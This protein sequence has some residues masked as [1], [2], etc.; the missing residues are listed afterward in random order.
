MKAVIIGLFLL[1]APASARME[2]RTKELYDAAYAD[3]LAAVKLI[4]EESDQ[5]V[6]VPYG[7]GEFSP[8]MPACRNGNLEMAELLV[9]KGADVSAADRYGAPVLEYVKMSSPGTYKRLRELIIKTAAGK[10]IELP[11]SWQFITL[12]DDM[13][14]T[15]AAT[16]DSILPPANMTDGEPKTAWAGKTGDELWVFV[17]YGTSS[18]TVT[19]GYNKTP[20]LFKAN[21]RVKRMAVSIWAAA[22][23]GGDVTEI[24]KGF[25]VTRLTPDHVITLKDSGAGQSFALPFDW[26]EID[27]SYVKAPAALFKR[28]NFGDNELYD[29]YFT[30]RAEPLEAYPGSKYDDT[31]I[32]ELRAGGP[33]REEPHLRG[34]WVSAE[35]TD[36]K[37][38]VFSTRENDRAF[39]AYR[40]GKPFLNGSWRMENGELLVETEGETSRYKPVVERIKY[41]F[42]LK[43]TDKDGKTEVYR[44]KPE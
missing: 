22:H 42:T 19:N 25:R 31:C 17:N 24:A 10:K 21:N 41:K 12:P 39:A 32:S 3:D 7:K 13:P 4:L 16:Y 18:M 26:E 11:V 40:D 6:N 27:K 15:A 43:L 44:Q 36:G 34:E 29:L 37:T 33:W 8:L 9:S 14:Y 1:P 20:K 2:D 30:L 35:G 23:F 5:N 28:G 38:L